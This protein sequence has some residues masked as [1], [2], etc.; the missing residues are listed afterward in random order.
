[1]GGALGGGH[2]GVEE[3]GPKAL[4]QAAEGRGAGAQDRHVH[5]HGGPDAEQGRVPGLVGVD[6]HGVNVDEAE[7]GDEAG[8][9][10]LV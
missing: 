3:F 7:D 4:D 9:F 2:D 6:G 5:L 8:S 1:M 10:E